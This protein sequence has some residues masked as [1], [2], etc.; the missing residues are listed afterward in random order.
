MK[1]I[2][3]VV[4]NYY[5]DVSKGL[6][7]SAKKKFSKNYILEIKEVP[8]VF[9]IPV[10][11]SKHIKRYDGFLALGCVIKGQTPHFDFISQA[12][13]NAIMD[14]SVSSKKPIG[15]GVITCLNMKQARARRKKG[16]EAAD[17]VISVL[18]Y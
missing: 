12:T 10:L 3:F 18:S 13:T 4:A 1:K 14:L 6:I 11:I 9:E 15:N 16:A 2:L 5:K 7:Q 8:G 17:A